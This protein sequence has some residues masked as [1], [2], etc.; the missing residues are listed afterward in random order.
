MKPAY[1]VN[2]RLYLT[3]TI[4]VIAVFGVLTALGAFVWAPGPHDNDWPLLMWLAKQAMVKGDISALALG[5]YG[6]AQLALAALLMPVFGSTLFAAKALNIAA[7]LGVLAMAGDIGYRLSGM[8]RIRLY[9]VMGIA[10]LPAF[11][12]TVQSEFGDP[13]ATF[14]FT[15]ALWFLTILAGNAR[16]R[17][18]FAFSTGAFLGCAGLVRTHF[19]VFGIIILILASVVI[20]KLVTSERLR[21]IVAMG[22]GWIAFSLPGFVLIFLFHHTIFSPV[23]PFFMGQAI[24]GCDYFNMASTYNLHPLKDVL[25]NHLPQFIHYL[26]YQAWVTKRLWIL[27]ILIGTLL[28]I[29]MKR[30][31]SPLLLIDTFLL[32]IAALYLLLLLPGWSIKLR[33]MLPFLVC[34]MILAGRTIDWIQEEKG[35]V[36]GLIVFILIIGAGVGFSIRDWLAIPKSMNSKSIEL[37]INLRRLGLTDPTQAFVFNWNRWM[38]RDPWFSAYYN[39]GGWNLL[40]PAFAI[41]RPNPFPC[42]NDVDRFAEF[43]KNRHVRF[44]VWQ[45]GLNRFQNLGNAFEVTRKVPGYQLAAELTEDIIFKSDSLQ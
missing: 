4:V 3:A 13:L 21:L 12:V 20:Y 39:F 7:T 11:S 40:S 29:R 28:F 34:I 26:V 14:F 30:R 17:V 45:K 9:T 19:Q 24:L 43:M 8:A 41:E 22:C 23:A 10:V 33:H 16:H 25:A 31:S 27:L 1:P 32:C 36:A 42:T 15:G 18:S 6:P 2:D 44:I 37:C 35:N 5:H 38:D